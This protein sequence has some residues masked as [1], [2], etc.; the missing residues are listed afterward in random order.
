MACESQRELLEKY[1]GDELPVGTMASVE[2]HVAQCLECAERLC[3]LL[4]LGVPAEAALQALPPEPHAGL[5]ARINLLLPPQ[6]AAQPDTCYAL[7]VQMSALV[8]GELSADEEADLRA[9]VAWCRSCAREL[10]ALTGMQA[11]MSRLNVRPRRSLVRR[12]RQ[13]SRRSG[14][15]AFRP[16]STQLRVR[17]G[18]VGAFAV[19]VTTA[20][21]FLAGYSA[22]A[23]RIES[24]VSRQ[25]PIPVADAS[26][27]DHYGAHGSAVR[28]PDVPSSLPATT[29]TPTTP[30][31]VD[32]TS[33]VAS[34][35]QGP[36]PTVVNSAKGSMR[37][38]VDSGAHLVESF[39]TVGSHS[40]TDPKAPAPTGR[41]AS[42]TTAPAG[43]GG[44]RPGGPEDPTGT[45]RATPNSATEGASNR[46]DE[47]LRLIERA[48]TS[49]MPAATGAYT[50]GGRSAKAAHDPVV[51]DA[52][53]VSETPA[54]GED[55]FE[56]AASASLY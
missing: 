2:A 41:G 54:S 52:V 48:W 33:A 7:S 56:P 16:V 22:G 4:S 53:T 1:A 15:P 20:A 21:V 12:L 46:T 49:M 5:K 40:G 6:D 24:A 36:S 26:A 42:G 25:R 44:S 34:V 43:T 32:E 45:S 17:P 29:A 14:V 28:T 23:L 27:A 8:D 31:V 10:S 55:E 51:V 30:E 38:L 9:H 3:E 39:S 35:A 50:D 11:G 18:F 47:G 13:V 37:R 19:A